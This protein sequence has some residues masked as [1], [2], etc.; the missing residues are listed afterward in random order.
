MQR[1]KRQ[2]LNVPAVIYKLYSGYMV[3]QRADK[4]CKEVR[5]DNY[6]QLNLE[7]ATAKRGSD[8]GHQKWASKKFSNS[9]WGSL[10]TLY[11]F[12]YLFFWPF[13]QFEYFEETLSAVDYKN[14]LITIITDWHIYLFTVYNDEGIDPLSECSTQYYHMYIRFKGGRCNSS[15]ARGYNAA[16]WESWMGTRML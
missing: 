6:G 4:E 5:R 10:D 8:T 1:I 13:H 11:I 12:F 16:Q 7:T 9:M 2:D 15:D 3:Q 14:D